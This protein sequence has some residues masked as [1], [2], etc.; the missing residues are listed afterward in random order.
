M[1][2]MTCESCP[3]TFDDGITAGHHEIENAGHRVTWTPTRYDGHC[4]TCARTTRFTEGKCDYC[5]A[6][7]SWPA[8]AKT[9]DEYEQDAENA[10]Q[11][12]SEAISEVCSAL[13]QITEAFA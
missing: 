13:D 3:A 6:G 11:G 9:Y 7:A 10:M 8:P 2:T 1:T 4:A 12:L 5:A